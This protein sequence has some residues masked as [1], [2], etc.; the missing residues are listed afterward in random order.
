MHP[1]RYRQC[2]QCGADFIPPSDDHRRCAKYCTRACGWA[3]Q[4][5]AAEATTPSRGELHALYVVQGLSIAAV[6]RH[7]GRS[8]WWAKRALA[9]RGIP[10]RRHIRPTAQCLQC[11]ATFNTSASTLKKGH[12]KYCSIACRGKHQGAPSKRPG[13]GAKIAEAKR[14]PRN[15]AFKTGL[16]PSTVARNGINLKAK[17]EGCCRACGSTQHLHLHHVIPRSMWRRG[18]TELLNCIPLC[19][20]CHT[21][22]HRRWRTI[23]R[24]V[25]TPEEWA[26]ISAADL[27]GQNVTAWLDDR[28]PAREW[29][30]V[31]RREGRAA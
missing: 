19:V 31:D 9:T 11:G 3:A 1:E 28:Y 2:A 7:Y 20:V 15:A 16:D 27:L 12:G 21:G 23:Y 8:E 4:K 22:W 17:G 25:F 14:G 29:V 18:I 24:D 26:F 6:G 5:A 10:E 13:A 30:P